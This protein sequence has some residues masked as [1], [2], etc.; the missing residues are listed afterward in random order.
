MEQYFFRTEQMTVGY[1][2]V[3]L[4]N[5]IEMQVEKGEILTLIGPNG[6]GKSTI[7][8]SIS[9]QLKLLS[10][11]VYLDQESLSKMPD[12]ERAKQM[13]VLLTDRVRPELMTCEDV[14]SMGR[15]PY[16]GALGLL[17]DADRVI[18]N[19][20]MEQT[21]TLEFKERD[22]LNTSD[23]QRQRVLLARALCQEPDILVLD[24]PTSFLDIRY[25]LEFMAVLKRLTREQHLAVVLSLH[26]LDLAERISDRVMC[27]KGEY[28][29][30]IG[31]PKEIF[32]EEYIEELFHL[33]KELYD[34]YRG[35]ENNDMMF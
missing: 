16:T 8:K 18:V 21:N 10:G 15:Y 17:T 11:T 6:A 26:E 9:S 24:E 33:S 19:N 29:D 30:R 7:L 25:K 2:G 35:D 5:N 20:V 22:F 12:N 14:V 34:W 4:I 27:V 31:T 28:I 23:G 1:D 3:P 32:T 13:A